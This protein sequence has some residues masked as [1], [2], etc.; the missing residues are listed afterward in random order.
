MRKYK[1][2]N[3]FLDKNTLIIEDEYHIQT[4]ISVSGKIVGGP[5]ITVGNETVVIIVEFDNDKD[6]HVFVYDESG[7]LIEKRLINKIERKIINTPQVTIDNQNKTEIDDIKTNNKYNKIITVLI[8][9]II[10][11]ILIKIII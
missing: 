10:L 3:V 9:G 7:R 11:G 4:S 6:W 1:I 2:T 8:I 5:T